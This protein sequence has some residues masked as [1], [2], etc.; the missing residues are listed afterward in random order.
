MVIKQLII[1]SP[2]DQSKSLT[3]TDRHMGTNEDESED[4]A[5]PVQCGRV[6]GRVCLPRKDSVSKL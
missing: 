4:T 5:T 1:K 6:T 3:N 2:T